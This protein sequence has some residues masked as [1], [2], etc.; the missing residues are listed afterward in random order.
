VAL[1]P[2]IDINR[3][4]RNGRSPESG[5]EEP[6]LIGKMDAALIRGIRVPQAIATPKHFAAPSHRQNRRGA[7]YKIDARTLREFYGPPYWM[8]VQQG[9]PWSIIYAYS[10]INGH[11][12]SAN[13]ELL[14]RTLRDERGFAC[15]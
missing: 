12:S 3:D 1:A 15:S 11:P 8:A 5:G 7:D 10:W 14:T 13:R 9:W 2:C 4:P 6:L